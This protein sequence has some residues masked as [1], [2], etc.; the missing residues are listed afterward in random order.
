MRRRTLLLVCIAVLAV[1]PALG[2]PLASPP[3]PGPDVNGALLQMELA[4]GGPVKATISTATGM[5]TFL[6]PSRPIPV[7][8]A[9]ST[10]PEDRARAFLR[11]YGRA[12]GFKDALAETEL[13]SPAE[14][15]ELG[16]DHVRFRQVIRGVRVT[17]GEITV[18]LRDAY[19]TAVNG[20]ILPGVQS[21]D[22]KPSISAETA[23][24]KAD[25]L[26]ARRLNRTDA[27]LSEPRLEILN[28]GL[29]EERL[30]ATRLTWFFEARGPALREYI[31]IDAKK[32]NPLLHF[33]QLTTAL[34]R[35]IYDGDSTDTLPGTLIR[36]EGGPVTGDSDADAA[37]TYSGDTYNYYFSQHGRDSFDGAGGTL[38]STVHH[39]PDAFDCPYE[40]AFWDG[41]QM[42]Y[43]DGFSVADDV[44]AHELTHAVTERTSNLFYYMQSGALNES[45]SDM[46]GETVDLTN[47][48]GTDTPAVRWK[49]GEDVPGFGA[50]RDMMNPG[51]FS[52]PAKITDPNYYCDY[53][54]NGGVHFNSGVSNHF[55]ALLA[56][57]GT[58]NSVSVTGIG[59]TKA[60]KIAYRTLTQYLVSGSGFRDAA[61]AFAQS[62]SDLIGTAGISGA[63]CTQVS[64]AIA[65][66]EMSHVLICPGA[67]PVA[68]ALCPAGQTPT[69][70]FFDDVETGEDNENWIVSTAAGGTPSWYVDNSF[71]TSPV[72]EFWGYD[73]FD[74]T[75]TRLQM[76]NSVAIPSGA[77][78]Q[79]NHAWD[80]DW[81]DYDGGVVEYSTNGGSSW[82]D[83][84]SLFSGGATYGGVLDSD[85]GNPLAGR[86]AFVNSS[87]GYTSTQLN[88]ASLAGQSNVKFRFR[89][90][91]DD[92][93]DW[94][95]WFLDDIRI[96]TCA[97]PPVCTYNL[98]ASS[99][100][101]GTAGG[102]GTVDVT[103]PGG[104]AW[105]SSSP[106]AWITISS[107]GSG[108]GTAS[109]TVAPNPGAPRSATLTIA[110]QPFTV[111]QEGGT[112]FYTVTAC[113][114]LDTRSSTSLTTGVAQTFT[115]TG[116]CGIPSTAKAISVN[117]TVLN[118]T[119]SGNVRVYPADIA[120]PAISTINF[121]ATGTRANNAIVS[122]AS[123]GSGTIKAYA[124]LG[125]GGTTVDLLIDV[126]GYYE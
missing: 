49:M 7:T 59:L 26:L 12:F 105:T 3:T 80:F 4:S 35:Q 6:S 42:V 74:I 114:L 9:A 75:D 121:Q 102:P 94:Y 8:G 53:L 111:N 36:S 90:A 5:A 13:R 82:T 69:N 34:N 63:D 29:L 117:V 112:D 122:L 99:A 71:A 14:R 54:D 89:L 45:F 19:V 68:P 113:R 91:T 43:G 41:D 108:N 81:P 76:A 73:Y 79:F 115:A 51:V 37:Y 98:S 52:D 47:S 32:G 20:E 25:E 21:L 67:P 55:Y 18:H 1:L 84:S 119:A 124:S 92:S 28:R 104:C 120:L 64:N 33:S 27:Q 57:G 50:L 17:A 58:Y 110:G 72:W 11:T 125:S 38:I 118:Q 106:V 44:D 22:L 77:R 46:F 107:A 56:D 40:N 93:L 60:G 126:S 65:A 39:C 30:H 61:S 83:A 2:Q 101:I 62:C 10:S 109:Y 97:A 48:G 95:G 100:T 24:A 31:W 103:A 78:M 86:S 85:F 116:S 123:D 23:R 87:Y 70:V 88:L 16:M 66:V 15:D 96:Y